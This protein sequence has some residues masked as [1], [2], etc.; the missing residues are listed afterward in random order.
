MAR[1]PTKDALLRAQKVRLHMLRQK[2]HEELGQNKRLTWWADEYGIQ[3]QTLKKAAA[4]QRKLQP[5]DALTIATYHGV[6]AQWVLYGEGPAARAPEGMLGHANAEP[7]VPLLGWVSAGSQVKTFPFNETELDH[8]VAPPGSNDRTRAL[9]VRGN[10]LGELFDRW[11][12]FF[13]DEH[14]SITPDLLNKLCIVELQDGRILVKKIRRVADGFDLLS[15]TEKPIKGA[16]IKWAA[17]VKH[18][19]P[20]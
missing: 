9:E 16:Q 18:M 13:D 4:G 14:R 6:T 15:N 1:I 12:V 11:I 8:V 20:R 2:K 3:Y 5:D 17:R 7:T 10:S 19:A